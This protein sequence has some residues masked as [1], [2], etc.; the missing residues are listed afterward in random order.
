MPRD[1][2]IAASIEASKKDALAKTSKKKKD[3]KKSKKPS[4]D[5]YVEGHT[6]QQKVLKRLTYAANMRRTDMP[7]LHMLNQILEQKIKNSTSLALSA[8]PSTS[9][10]LKTK[11]LQSTSDV[12]MFGFR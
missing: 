11:H 7:I 5:K 12:P 2:K 4:S 6:F 9:K 3:E 1:K 8:L 10:T